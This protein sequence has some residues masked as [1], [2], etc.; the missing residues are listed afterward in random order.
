VGGRFAVGGIAGVELLLGDLDEGRIGRGPAVA[1]IVAV[2]RDTPA[3]RAALLAAGGPAMERSVCAPIG[4]AVR[5]QPVLAVR[6][7]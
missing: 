5:A 6:D 7:G 3:I 4:G 2:G 1:W